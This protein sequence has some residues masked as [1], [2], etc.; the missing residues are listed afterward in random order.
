MDNIKHLELS[1]MLN[2]LTAAKAKSQRDFCIVLFAFRFGL[3]SQELALLKLDDVSDGFC[4]VKRLKG[5]LHTRQAITS[6]ANPLLNV[7]AALADWL[8]LREDSGS[9]FLFTSRLGGGMTRRA[10]FNIFE[11][12]A[13]HAGIE[14]G[15]RN[16][17]ICKHSLAVNLRKRGVTVDIVQRALGHKDPATTLRYYYHTSQDEATKA[18]QN[19]FA[20]LAP[21]TA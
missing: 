1:E 17:H 11:D 12:A 10:I 6:D 18:I 4:D 5:S 2:V 16:V 20:K 13:F 14:P 7:E 21:A 8:R 3:R 9:V 19:A 15:R